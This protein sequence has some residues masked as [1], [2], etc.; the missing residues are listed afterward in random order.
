MTPI[1]NHGPQTYS[2]EKC[3]WE[4]YIFL[5][6]KIKAI[7]NLGIKTNCACIF[8]AIYAYLGCKK[9]LGPRGASKRLAKRGHFGGNK[10]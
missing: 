4:I 8:A 2:I 5:T 9:S 10:D 3:C 7:I 1:V 6:T